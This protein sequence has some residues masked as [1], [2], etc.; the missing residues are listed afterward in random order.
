MIRAPWLTP[1]PC[2]R[3]APLVLAR[4]P[5][6]ATRVSVGAC[7]S[8]CRE[9]PP[10]RT[11][12]GTEAPPRALSSTSRMI[13]APWLTPRPCRRD[14]SLALARGPRVATRV[15]VGACASGCREV[16]RCS[17]ARSFA[18]RVTARALAARSVV[19]VSPPRPLRRSIH[20]FLGASTAQSPTLRRAWARQLMN[21]VACGHR[22]WASNDVAWGYVA[23]APNDE[24]CGVR[25]SSV[26]VNDDRCCG[27]SS[28]RTVAPASSAPNDER[29]RVRSS[30]VRAER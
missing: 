8:G 9:R 24:R 4:A 3:D 7:A 1:R 25:S 17:I 11:R 10:D 28:V 22:A 5:R 27:S 12:L 13:R 20:L 21:D 15:S 23:C 16:V 26:R 19:R 2:R 29:C 14:A 18:A 30:S 6:V